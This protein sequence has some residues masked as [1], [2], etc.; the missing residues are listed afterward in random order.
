MSI[1]VPARPALAEQ[2]QLAPTRTL[3]R[4]SRVDLRPAP[5]RRERLLTRAISSSAIW[6]LPLLIVQAW[7]SFR[8]SNTLEQDEAL[9][10][11]AG[12]QLIAHMLHGTRTP[13][14]GSYFSGV[15]ALY[16]VPAAMLDHVGGVRLV[17]AANTAMVM[18][19]TIFVYLSTRRIFTHS[20]ALIAAGVF[21][22]N[23]AVIFV[24]RF[25]SFDAPCLLL[26][27]VATYLAVRASDRW[28]FALAVGP[29]LALATAEKYFAL[30]FIPSVLAVL[31]IVSVRRVGVRR[32]LRVA[33]VAVVG[34]AVAGGIAALVI[35]P[36]DW[37]GLLATSIRRS[38]ILP[39]ARGTLLRSCIH[40]IGALTAAGLVG[41]VVARRR[42]LLATVLLLTA[43]IPAFV[44][45]KLGESASLHKNLAF[46]VL[47]LSPLVGVAGVAL[48]RRGRLLVLRAP[49]A[50][51]CIALVLSSGMGTSAAMVHGWPNSTGIDAVLAQYVHPGGGQYLV[52]N[53]QV[54]EYYLSGLSNYT[55]WDTTFAPVYQGA[56]GVQIMQNQLT[57]GEFSLFLYGDEG[58]TLAL[59]H[60]M[61]TVLE[62]R[63]TL[64][65]KVPL[66][67]TDTHQFWYLWRAELP[68]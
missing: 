19:A 26:L 17:H 63:Y 44:Q 29:C 67:A 22:V 51:A 65:A 36:L 41:V 40:Y 48:L 21:A 42:W 47:F 43:L 15:P 68:R 1:D 6:L 39:E 4:P 25:A 28:I 49:A 2:V 37:Q 10:I 31:V 50:L 9:Y 60:Q 7:F 55:Q 11:N 23:P 53:S 16:A 38:A 32:G 45:I 34:L 61:L 20:A 56:N 46:G 5:S 30:A 57:N 13:A 52:D 62:R 18:I 35:A 33:V 64:V 59:D 3:E 12:H 24:G 14:F 8:L 66:S 58:S 54:P 27:A